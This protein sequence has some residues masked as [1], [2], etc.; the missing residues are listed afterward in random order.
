MVLLSFLMLGRSHGTVLLWNVK[1]FPDWGCEKPIPDCSIPLS[2]P[3]GSWRTSRLIDD[4]TKDWRPLLLSHRIEDNYTQGGSPDLWSLHKKEIASGQATE[5]VAVVCYC[6]WVLSLLIDSQAEERWE[7]SKRGKLLFLFLIFYI[8]KASETQACLLGNRKE[9]VDRKN[10]KVT[11]ERK[12]DLWQRTSPGG[13]LPSSKKEAKSQI[14]KEYLAIQD[15]EGGQGSP[16]PHQP[17]HLTSETG[18]W[19][20]ESGI[21]R[22]EQFQGMTSV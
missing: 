11:E 4:K 1:S 17:M 5:F 10:L 19:R 21:L 9:S 14:H 20:L 8:F 15:G 22:M 18:E 16:P 3:Q 2:L 6:K 12:Q 7:S 13:T